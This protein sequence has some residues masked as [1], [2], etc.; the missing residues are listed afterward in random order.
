MQGDCRTFSLSSVEPTWQQQWLTYKIQLASFS[1]DRKW[2][3]DPADFWGCSSEVS[4]W[5][6]NKVQIRNNKWYE[7][8]LCI[9]SLKFY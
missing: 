1:W 5:D 8:H 7:Q 2:T 4:A 9:Q 3:S 6:V